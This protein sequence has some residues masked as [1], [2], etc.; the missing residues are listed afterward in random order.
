MLDKVDG[1]VNAAMTGY[2]NHGNSAINRADFLEYLQAIHAR[3]DVIQNYQINFITFSAALLFHDFKRFFSGRCIRYS[4]I[5][6][7]QIDAKYFSN[8]VVVI[9]NEN[10]L[11]LVFH[12]LYPLLLTCMGMWMWKTL[13]FL[14]GV[15][16]RMVP[17]S[18]FP[19]VTE[20][21]L[22]NGKVSTSLSPGHE[23]G[24]GI[25]GKK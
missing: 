8:V 6:R 17:F 3:H 24:S 15:G 18:I 21:S 12:Y 16:Q 5:K 20:Y 11:M 23:P 10:A 22:F 1:E 4:I 7:F 2:H 14:V 25:T 13:P 9:N 19:V